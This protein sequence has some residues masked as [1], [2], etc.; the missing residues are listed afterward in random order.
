[1]VATGG[2]PG[3]HC[4]TMSAVK[5]WLAICMH[6][7]RVWR[8]VV[9]VDFTMLP[10]SLPAYRNHHGLIT[11]THTHR[12]IMETL[13]RECVVALVRVQGSR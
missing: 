8:N 13:S 12:A 10:V 2:E 3:G 9:H 11:H 4:D 6:S 7:S 1:M 5:V